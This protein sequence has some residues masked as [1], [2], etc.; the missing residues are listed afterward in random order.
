MAI[1]KFKPTTPSRRKMAVLNSADLTVDANVPRS[2][3]VATKSKA[4]RNNHGRITTRHQG[5]GAKQKYRII[6]FKRNKF[7][8]PAKVE[9]IVYD[10]N[11]TCNIALL[12]YADGLKNFILAPLGMN[13]GDTIISSNDADIKPGN[14][15]Q[16]KDV[17]IGTLVHNVELHVGAGGQ[18]ARSAGSYV[19]VMA[20]EGETVLLRLPSG[21]LRRVRDNCRATIGQVGNLDHEN[22]VIGKAG[23]NRHRG[24]RPAVRGVAMNPIDHPHGGGEGRTSG[25]RHPVTPWG[26]PTRGYKTRNNKRTDKF[27][28]KRRK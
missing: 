17:P 8:I 12:C 6:D 14:S 20:K 4:G 13:V 2:L 10:P 21:E 24:V 3:L 16:L 19:Q 9:A 25:G 27:I 11:R 1:K 5:G 15:K 28:V 7:D 23:A 22:R 18:M 26:Q